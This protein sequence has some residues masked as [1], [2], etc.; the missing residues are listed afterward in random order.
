MQK[1]Q[2]TLVNKDFQR[3]IKTM[4]RILPKLSFGLLIGTYLIT[5]LI[6]AIFHT[7]SLYIELGIPGAVAA[8][9]IPLAIQAGRGT[10]V[11]FFQLNPTRMQGRFSLGAIAATVLLILSIYE[12]YLVMT[13]YGLSWTITVGTLMLIGWVIEIMIMKETIFATQYELYENKEQWNELKKFYIAKD[14]FEQFMDDLKDGKFKAEGNEQ[15][16]EDL[17]NKAHQ[18][19]QAAPINQ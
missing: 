13:P 17:L 2:N 18:N 1:S 12:A 5:A 6:M 10:L 11:F 7:K 19:G 15:S 9:L 4:R 3:A 14:Q 16:L 8:C